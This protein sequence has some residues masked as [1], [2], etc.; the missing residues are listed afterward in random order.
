MHESEDR[1][2]EPDVVSFLSALPF[3]REYAI[4]IVSVMPG[5]VTI[6]LPFDERFSGPPSRG[7]QVQGELG[8]RGKLTN[9]ARMAGEATALYGGFANS[10]RSEEGGHEEENVSDRFGGPGYDCNM[11]SRFVRSSASC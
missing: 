10:N 7:L 6:D 4:S 3:V 1:V 11:P 8:I 5:E 9:K 2:T